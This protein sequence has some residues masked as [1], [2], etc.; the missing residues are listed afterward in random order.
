MAF[1]V[2]CIGSALLDVYLKSDKFVKVVSGVFSGGVALNE[3]FGGKTEVQEMTLTS[4]GGGTN[5]AVSFARKGLSTALIAEMG[6]DLVAATI[7]EE[8]TREAVDT[9]FLV[10]EADEVTGLSSI[11]VG[12]DGS[13]S[14]AVYRG[15][16][17]LLTKEDMPWDRLQPKWFYLSSL[18]GEMALLEGLIGHAKTFGFK[19]ALNP[20]IKEIERLGEWGG[21]SLFDGI[22]VLLVNREEAA[23][24]SDLNF[25]DDSIW[26]SDQTIPGPE[27]VVITDGRRG[28]KVVHQGQSYFYDILPVPTVEE[29]GA[30][31]AFGS[32]FVAALIKDRPVI[33][34]IDWGKRQA[35]SVVQFMGAKKGLLTLDQL[36]S[37]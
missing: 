25:L 37:T 26:L 23:K 12:A 8:L 17:G 3:E 30:G 5:T 14:V 18:G 24:L 4:G 31:D 10:E 27:Y 29:T 19:I 21:V 16:S 15:A 7:K 20:G 11:L 34:A 9:S 13:R 2:V 6:T 32:A 33:E 35:A 28:G 36:T 22:T 1:D